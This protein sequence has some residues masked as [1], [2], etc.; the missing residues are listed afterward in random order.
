[1]ASRNYFVASF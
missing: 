1:M